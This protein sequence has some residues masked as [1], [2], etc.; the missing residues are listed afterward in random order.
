[1]QEFETG[2][3]NHEVSVGLYWRKYWNLEAMK[4]EWFW[5]QIDK[6]DLIEQIFY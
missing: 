6:Y 5:Y 3:V 4:T 2:H 1:M